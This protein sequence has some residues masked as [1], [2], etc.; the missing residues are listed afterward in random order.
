[1]FSAYMHLFLAT[2]ELLLCYYVRRKHKMAFN[3]RLAIVTGAGS[4]RGIGRAVA[5]CLAAKG[6]NIIVADLNLLGAQNVAKEITVVGRHALALQVDVSKHA[7]VHGM[8]KAAMQ[9]FKR[10]DILV[11][12]AGITQ[13][14]KV[15][16]TTEEDFD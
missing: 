15:I 10:I 14:A 6:A 11:N 9:E 13:P 5:L 8:V 12:N 16:D 4:P 3:E 2:A 7:S 1:M